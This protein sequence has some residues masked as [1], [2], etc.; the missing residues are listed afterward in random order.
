MPLPILPGFKL[1]AGRLRMWFDSSEGSLR[2]LYADGHEV[3]RSIVAPVRDAVWATLAPK[4]GNVQVH[5]EADSFRVSFDVRC[6]HDAA[7]FRWRGLIAGTAENI[8]T[9]EFEGEAASDFDSNRIGFCVLHPSTARGVSC[10]IEHTDGSISAGR[11]PHFIQPHVLFTDLRAITHE[12]APGLQAEVRME[13]GQFE[14]EDQ[15][16]WTDA[17]FKT[18]SPPLHL[19]RP[20]RILRGTRIRQCVTVRIHGKGAMTPAPFSPRWASP[21]K[22]EVVVGGQSTK[23]LPALGTRWNETTA[24][25]VTLAEL[26]H[27]RLAH[28]RVDFW[29]GDNACA[30]R[31]S[32]AAI[33]ANTLNIALELV[34][35]AHDDLLA[36]LAHVCAVLE[37]I[38]PQPRIARWFI[39]HEAV[40]S[41]PRELVALA[42]LALAPTVFAAPV[43]GGSC[44]NFTELNRDHEAAQ[45][46]DFTAHACNP[47]VHAFDDASMV[48]T[49]A[50]QAETAENARRLSQGRPVILS[51][52]TLTRRWRT[53]EAGA[54]AGQPANL[55]PFQHDPRHCSEFNAAW[56]FGSI[57]ALARAGVASAT[58][59]EATGE[60]GLLSLAHKP[61]PVFE[62]LRHATAVATHALRETWSSHPFIVEAL[63]FEHAGEVQLLLGNLTRTSQVASIRFGQQKLYVTFAPFEI[64]VLKCS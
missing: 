3:L 53:G 6:K 28:L 45:I 13:G 38:Q 18:Y 58:Y 25:A 15:R 20:I 64:R 44:D 12:V 43:G 39:L 57:A 54:P 24:S 27:L 47:Q 23:R 34:V 42:R 26:Q 29:A 21:D 5:Q 46:S 49:L 2:Y 8:L 37:G 51:L 16:N 19:P 9:F 40:G 59:F 62:T 41:T 55:L 61:L 7:D 17:S 60:N 14:M 48:E 1:H 35:F 10:Q 4:I 31:L 33:A 36:T 11:F 56:T 32:A 30:Q 50:M 52:V 22:V 63:A